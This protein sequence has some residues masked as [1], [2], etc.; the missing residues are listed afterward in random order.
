MGGDRRER[1][2]DLQRPA[3]RVCDWDFDRDG[4]DDFA[5][6]DAG[7]DPHTLRSEGSESERGAVRR[8]T[9]R[10]GGAGMKRKRAIA[11]VLMA[12]LREIFD[13]AAYQRLLDRRELALARDTHAA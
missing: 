3:G 8:N 7:V 2:A 1:P 6:V 13:E 12:I 5:R 11:A 4:G 10:H 9:D